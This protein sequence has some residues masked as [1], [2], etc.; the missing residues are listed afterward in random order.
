MTQPVC[1]TDH[2]TDD[3]AAITTLA[4]LVVWNAARAAAAATATAAVA[5]AVA[6]TA[7]AAAASD[8]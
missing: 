6:V 7:A 5:A 3:Q 4:A 8:E 2:R 1:F